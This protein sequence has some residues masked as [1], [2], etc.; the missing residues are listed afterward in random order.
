MKNQLF[1]YY[2]GCAALLT[3][4]VGIFLPPAVMSIAMMALVFLAIISPQKGRVWQVF[5]STP[6]LWSISGLC[7]LFAISGLYSDDKAEYIGRLQLYAPYLFLPVAVLAIPKFGKREYYSILSLF[8]WLIV[9]ISIYLTLYYITHFEEMNEAYKRGQVLPTP[10]MHI[11]FSLM[12]VY[13]VYIGVQNFI[14]RWHMIWPAERWL[15]LIGSIFL[16]I[17]IHILAVRSGMVTLYASIF[18]A[19]LVMGI[20]KKAY[21]KTGLIIASLVA[22]G[23]LA[24]VNVPTLQNKYRYTKYNLEEF[25]RG[26]DIGRLSDSYRIV[27]VQAG[28]DIGNQS[29]LIGVGV[30]DVRNLTAEYVAEHY[31]DLA[32][33]TYSPQNQFVVIYSALGLVGV[34]YFL[35]M[36]FA[37]L[38]LNGFWSE[39]QLI[40]FHTVAFCSFMFEQL[41]ETQIG[42]CFYLVFSLMGLRF[43][44]RD[45]META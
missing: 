10:I 27:S 31:P 14:N 42:I 45:R 6:A 17:F 26:N 38:R 28:L 29:P 39:W 37:P 24:V 35:F 43:L 8:F 33:I 21:L 23:I 32:H 3:A 9:G 44:L 4:A 5:K 11:H 30:G 13:C 41:L 15:Y 1:H 2:V 40:A 36:I 7:I 18:I 12:V 16:V 20:R 25:F 22:I 19:L 34:I